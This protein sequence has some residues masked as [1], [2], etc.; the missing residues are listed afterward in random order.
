MTTLNIDNARATLDSIRQHGPEHFSM[1]SWFR[2]ASRA[3]EL[4]ISSASRVDFNACGTTGCLAGHAAYAAHQMGVDVSGWYIKETADW[5][6]IDPALNHFKL[7]GSSQWP[8][9]DYY[10][11]LLADPDIDDATAEWATVIWGLEGLI[12][13]AEADGR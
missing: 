5:L 11:K 12:K 2:I 8:W 6:G 7:L 3:A 10:Q 13:D 1:S 4:C 9:T